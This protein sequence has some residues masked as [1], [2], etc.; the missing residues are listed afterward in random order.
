MGVTCE[1][2][3]ALVALADCLVAPEAALVEKPGEREGA[4]GVRVGRAMRGWELFTSG[5]SSKHFTQH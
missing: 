5:E 2:F 4:G 1:I 3:P